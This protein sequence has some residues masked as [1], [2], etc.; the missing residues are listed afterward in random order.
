M[1]RMMIFVV[2]STIL[3]ST[4]GITAQEELAAGDATGD[5]LDY[6]LIASVY[7]DTTVYLASWNPSDTKLMTWLVSLDATHRFSYG[8][9]ELTLVHKTSVSGTD[10]VHTVYEAYLLLRPLDFLDVYIGRKRM[11]IGSGMTFAPGD[12]FNPT[13]WLFDSKTGG[14]DVIVKISPNSFLGISAGVSIERSFGTPVPSFAP[15]LVTYALETDLVL[16]NLQLLASFVFCPD[17]TLNLGTGFSLDVF[18]IIVSAEGALELDS[19]VWRVD[20]SEWKQAEAFTDPRFSGTAGA[21]Y[22]IVT[23]DVS[24]LLSAEYIYSGQS[25]TADETTAWEN[26]SVPFKLEHKP[27]YFRNMHNVAIKTVFSGWSRLGINGTVVY[28]CI[29][30]SMLLNAGVSYSPYD[31]VD[32]VANLLT[33]IGGPDSE[34]EYLPIPPASSQAVAAITLT[35]RFHI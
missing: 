4:V 26:S 24:L 21:R 23:E 13:G 15:E 27:P 6:T 25:W 8:D 1:R 12:S 19:D 34:R 2:I 20:G 31:N 28:N 7:E 10:I 30:S 29:D 35:A 17:K 11:N 18:G 9:Y 22:E 33:G 3:C 16:D 14:R 32:L 5:S